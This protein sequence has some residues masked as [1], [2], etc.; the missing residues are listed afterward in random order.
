MKNLIHGATLTL[1]LLGSNISSAQNTSQGVEL[2]SP[3]EFQS[4][5]HSAFSDGNL[6]IEQTIGEKC[7]AV[8]KEHLANKKSFYSLLMDKKYTRVTSD[9]NVSEVKDNV[10]F[11]YTKWA[12]VLEI[13]NKREY[14]QIFHFLRKRRSVKDWFFYVAA[15]PTSSAHLGA[16]RVSFRKR[17][18][19]FVSGSETHEMGSH[20][21]ALAV[22]DNLIRRFP[23]L[24]DCRGVGIADR[25]S[26]PIL[27]LLAAEANNIDFIAYRGFRGAVWFQVL[28]EWG[29]PG[30]MKLKET[31]RANTAPPEV[32]MGTRN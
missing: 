16:H 8:I 21:G 28:G 7:S 30:S 25:D 12:E 14:Y 27:A 9:S 4:S 20:E 2:F 13:F 11:H 26:H 29:F 17:A 5:L 3:L 1:M 10:F 15:D 18:K 19:I 23:H 31:P 22:E 6:V 32:V 24:A